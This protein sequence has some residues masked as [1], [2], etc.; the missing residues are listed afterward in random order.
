MNRRHFL[1][2]AGLL[3]ASGL[4]MGR[5][6][7]AQ[8]RALEQA[9]VVVI[10]GGFGGATAAKY[11]RLFSEGRV[12]VTLIE[13]K[14]R[15]VSCPLSNLVIGGSMEL[16]GLSSTYDGLRTHHGIDVVHE[17]ALAIDA[18]R[19]QVKLSGGQL[20]AYDRLIV[21]PGIDF[22]W[23]QVEGLE[24][25]AAREAL[26]HAWKAG[27]QTEQ[28]R[29]QLRAMPDGGVFA[30]SIPPEPYRCPPGPYERICQVAWYFKQHKP[31]AKILVFDA[32][33]DIVSKKAL[34]HQAWQS[35][36]EGM[37]EYQPSFSVQ[38]VD[39]ATRTVTSDMGERQRAD[40][41]NVLPPMRAGDIALKSGLATANGRWCEIDFLTF[42]SRAVPG[43]HVLGDAILLAPGMPKSAHMANQHAK[44]CAA[45]VVALLAE[46]PVNPLPIYAN[47]CYS[48]T[49]DNEVV[50]VSS[51]HRYDAAK[52]TMLPV[53]GAGGLSPEPTR[54]EGDYAWGWA[55]NIWAD[56]LA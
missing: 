6:A 8:G 21:S 19:R 3:G 18:E 17:Q 41:L 4:M 12:R 45:A 47:T 44:T 15:L 5:S 10:G 36:Y 29:D 52:A 40:V 30:L 28:L 13:P 2:H 16:E 1:R 33:A 51:V 49:S 31:R 56:A 54:Q 46:Q 38:E 35:Q 25:Q 55:R 53:S 20:V 50:H 7:F 26:P 27:P 24:T 39:A 14:R 32:N 42:E 37:I 48:F 43:V 23:E 22:M 34:F 9:H 11:L